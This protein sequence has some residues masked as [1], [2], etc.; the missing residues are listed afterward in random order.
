MSKFYDFFAIYWNTFSFFAEINP[1]HRKKSSDCLTF[2]HRHC[3]VALDPA[4]QALAL[5]SRLREVGWHRRER[6]FFQ[7]G[8][9]ERMLM[10]SLARIPSSA[11]FSAA[12]INAL[13]TVVG[14]SSPE[15]LAWLSGYLAGFA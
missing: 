7:I 8:P 3:G 5:F 1:N 10:S 11:P 9:L 13:N 12:E 14:R 6:L 15:Q 4:R 2:A